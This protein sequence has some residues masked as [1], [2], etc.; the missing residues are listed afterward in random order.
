VL[1][2]PALL[3]SALRPP[4]EVNRGGLANQTCRA[5]WL[6][7]AFWPALPEKAE[8]ATVVH[9]VTTELVEG[10]LELRPRS[11]RPPPEVQL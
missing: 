8:S 11:N 7:F 5:R 9:A 10:V 6:N 3:P 4:G 2:L 1:E